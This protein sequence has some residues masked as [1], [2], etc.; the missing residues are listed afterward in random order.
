MFYFLSFPPLLRLL[1][2][3]IP[4]HTFGTNTTVYL[5]PLA[6]VGGFPVCEN[7]FLYFSRSNLG[8]CDGLYAIYV[9]HHMF[10][11]GISRFPLC[12]VSFRGAA[13]LG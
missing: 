13:G 8:S 2:V 9:R 3:C 1:S 5:I 4:T 10:L 12:Y 7:D 6:W 11:L